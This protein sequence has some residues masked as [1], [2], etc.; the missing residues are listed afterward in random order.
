MK[1]V[2]PQPIAVIV[3]DAARSGAVYVTVAPEVADSVPEAGV[4]QV[5]EPSENVSWVDSPTP[6]FVRARLEGLVATAWAVTFALLQGHGA[7]AP[8]PDADEFDALDGVLAPGEAGVCLGIQ[9]K[10]D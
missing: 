1:A 5:A 8:P 10:T 9:F 6:S 3:T 4:L 7:A 2:Q